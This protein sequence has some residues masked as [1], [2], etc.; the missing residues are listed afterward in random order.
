[1]SKEE[2]E[3]S[4]EGTWTDREF[5]IHWGSEGNNSKRQEEDDRGEFKSEHGG[6]YKMRKGRGR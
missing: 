1:M 2:R 3:I 4:E 6:D 5:H